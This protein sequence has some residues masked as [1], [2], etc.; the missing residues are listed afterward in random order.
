VL[1]SLHF[2]AT[3]I[4]AHN[5]V[6]EGKDPTTVFVTGNPVVDALQLYLRPSTTEG[7]E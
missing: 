1:A 5:L 3:D 4:A 7:N 2:A 6:E